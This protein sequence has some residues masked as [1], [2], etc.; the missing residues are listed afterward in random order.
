MIGCLQF[1]PPFSALESRICIVHVPFLMFMFIL[2]IY[3]PLRYIYA[4]SS[5][6]QFILTYIISTQSIHK[7][8]E[9]ILLLKGNKCII[10]IEV[11]L[12]STFDFWVNE[13][14]VRVESTLLRPK[15]DPKKLFSSIFKN[16]NILPIMC[17]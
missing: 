15:S 5:N 6:G 4:L 10:L 8:K 13:L 11:H 16:I 1:V 12:L 9:N 17:I 7:G 2:K 3:V 14:R